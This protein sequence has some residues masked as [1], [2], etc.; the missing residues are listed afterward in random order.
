[1]KLR[2][3]LAP[4]LLLLAS[5]SQ[6]Q[7]PKSIGLRIESTHAALG[8]VPPGETATW[9]RVSPPP[10]ASPDPRYLQAA[11]FDETRRV[12][13]MFGGISD[14]DSS[15]NWVVVG[16]LWEWDPAAGT[17][18]NRTPSGSKPRPR[19]GAGMVFDST[20]KKFVIFGG[21]DMDQNDYQDTWEWD[22]TAGAFTDRTGSGPLPDARTEHSMV[23]EKS[24]G[25]VLLFGGEAIFGDNPPGDTWEWDPGTGGWSKLAPT[26]APSARFDSAMVWDSQRNRAVLFGGMEGGPD[27]NP[28]QDT[29]EWDPARS[30]WTERTAE[31]NKPNARYG[32]AMAYDPGRGVTVLVGGWDIATGNGLADVWEWDPTTAAWK[33]RLTG[34]EANLPTGRWYASL[35]TDSARNRLVLLAGET[36]SPPSLDPVASAEVWDLDPVAAT[37][38]NR[39][40]PSSHKAWPPRRSYHAMAFCPATGKMYMFGGQDQTGALLDD[41]WEWDGSTWSEVP[42]DVRPVPRSETAMAY[43]SVRK[44]LILFGGQGK[45]PLPYADVAGYMRDTW[46]WQSG[47]RKWTQLFPAS[48]PDA[49]V[50][51]GMVTDAGR[52]KVL[53]YGGQNNI[54]DPIPGVA[55]SSMAPRVWEWNGT[56]ATWTNRTP[57]VTM[58]AQYYGQIPPLLSFDDSRQKMFLFTSSSSENGLSSGSSFSEWDPVT[59]G[60]TY[61]D[62]GEFLNFN[63]SGGSFLA[64][65]SLRRRQVLTA[66][67]SDDT[68]TLEVYELDPRGPTWYLRTPSPGPSSRSGA[69]MAFDSGRGVMVLFGGGTDQPATSETWEYRVTKLGNGEGCTAATVSTCASG[70]CVE[71]VCCA[72]ASC[73]GA[74]QS[75]SVAGR[76]G[77]CV[78]AAAGT[79]VPSSCADG[80]ACDGSGKCKSKNGVA[81]A[82]ASACAS[83][84]CV[85]GVCCE[86][87]CDGTCVSCNQAARAGKCSFYAVASDPESECASGNDPCRSTCDGAG[88]CDYPEWRTPCGF[89]QTCDGNGVCA[90]S[91]PLACGPVDAG[92]AGAGGG[93]GAGGIGGTGA[94]GAGGSAG[95]IS[96]GAGGHGGAGGSSDS[97]DGGRDASFTDARGPD[98]ARDSIPPD[99]GSPDGARDSIQPDANRPDGGKDSILPD[100]GSAGGKRDSSAPDAGSTARLGHSGC[101]CDLGRTGP[102][103]PGLPLALLGATFLWRL[104]R[105]NSLTRHRSISVRVSGSV[106][107]SDQR[108]A[109]GVGDWRERTAARD[110][111]SAYPPRTRSRPRDPRSAGRPVWWLGVVLAALLLLAACSQDHPD[112]GLRTESPRL[113]LGTVPATES[114]TWKRVD[115]SAAPTPSSRYLQ[116]AAFD[117]TRKVLVMFGGQSGLDASGS[118]APSQELWEWDPATGSWTNRTPAGSKPSARSGAGMVFDSTRNKFVIVGGRAGTGYNYEDTWEWDPTTGAFTDRTNSGSRPP[119]RSL[120]SMVF[121]KSTGKVL[122]FGG[123][124]SSQESGFWLGNDGTGVASAYG[125]T[126]E[127]DPA[128][129]AWTELT[130]AVAPSARY[131]SALVWDSTRARAVLFGGKQEDQYSNPGIPCQDTWEWNPATPGWTERTT[132]GTKPSARFGHAMA[133][134]PGRGVMVLV[135]GVDRFT[136]ADVW[137]W[138]PATAA[139]ARRLAGSEANLPPARAYASLVT[140]VAQDRLYLMDGLNFYTRPGPDGMAEGQTIPFADLWELE[141]ATAVFTSRNSRSAP[142]ERSGFAMAFCPDNSK[143]YVFGGVDDGFQVLDDLWEWDGISWLQVE[144]Y[145][146]P[147]ARKDA[148]MAYDPFRQSLILFGGVANNP[149]NSTLN[150]LLADTWEWQSGTRKWSQLHPAAS[151]DPV[152]GHGM[153]TDSARAKVLLFGGE[154]P[155]FSDIPGASHYSWSNAVWEWDGGKTTWSNRTPISGALTPAGRVNPLLSFDEGR[156][157][158]FLFEGLGTWQ[159]TTSNSVFWEWDPVSA[160]WVFRDSGDFVDF[161]AASDSALPSPFPIVA[162]DSLRRRMVVPTTASTT[163]GSKTWE[164]DAKAPTWYL[165]TLSPSPSSLSTAAVVYDSQRGVMVL[166]GSGP[167]YSGSSETWEYKVANLGNGEGCTAARAPSCASGFCVDGVCCSI[168]AC[169]GVCQ[170]CSVA[171]HEGTCVQAAAGTEVPNS[172]SGSQACDGSGSCKTRNGLTCSSGSACASGFCVDG[173]CCESACDG[174]CVSCNQTGR[175][176][177]CTGYAAGSDPENEC[178]IGE[179]VCRATCNGS[180]ACDFAAMGTSC[181]SCDPC[182]CM[183]CTSDGRCGSWILP[184]CGNPPTGAGGVGGTGGTGAGGSGG[185]SGTGGRLTGGASGSGGMGGLGGT[186]SGGGASSSGGTMIAGAG[187]TGGAGGTIAGGGGGTSGGGGATVGGAGGRSSVGGASGIPDGGRDAIQPDASSPDGSKESIPPDAGNLV[188]LGHSGCSCN[189]API[190]PGTP[191]LP[192]ALFGAASFWRRLRRCR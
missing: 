32:H 58:N 127:W 170:S 68:A 62:P 99:T 47:T 145:V 130:L 187:G 154:S 148:A 190:S 22:P 177:Q 171:G 88:A 18:T 119:G 174:K 19:A 129:G 157:R 141:P 152:D 108:G 60:W 151:P 63:P 41:L 23:F 82:S 181:G 126:W 131:S 104:R 168:A 111:S 180:G 153:V 55:D 124:R 167:G 66:W 38:T 93:G 76:E 120:H 52:G 191:G 185:V 46:E 3:N 176:G 118:P 72:V 73:S 163:T 164:L 105:R 107:V 59:V 85:D 137:E 100:A 24:T 54:L 61:Q 90:P 136:V 138:D 2:R 192:F 74:C 162:Y 147:P 160:G 5:C 155:A 50:M 49:V 135:G 7:P 144:N 140:D 14:P 4:A 189:L 8:K 44:S 178:G 57:V 40:P 113:A 36:L 114:A 92:G 79:E 48:G 165:R 128:T 150:S 110:P 15:G 75:C 53:L 81:C 13:V 103:A 122:L 95:S 80:Q 182:A 166:F 172:C 11:A 158:M 115:V 102:G 101:D 161:G 42:S 106:S 64:F 97:P 43:D 96:G 1:M 159:G 78:R 143:T 188:R 186:N 84:F 33:L 37:F 67:T 20:R 28:E 112:D 31:G 179:G 39:T 71:G 132:D 125:D 77:T 173:V 169:S 175:A 69:T 98:G 27:G 94:G 123:G 25:K 183:R 29:W 70:F 30:T 83:G 56:T 149:A 117:D 142:A 156:Q 86:S 35:V 9:T 91:D 87:A 16:D 89:C 65:D 184:T 21:T 146:R 26:T 10:G 51:H 6:S 17:W 116:S 45:P 139:W 133:Y 12:L 121:E 109:G 34:S 134:D